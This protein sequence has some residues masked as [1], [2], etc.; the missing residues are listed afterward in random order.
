MRSVPT[1]ELNSW[2]LP[3]IT[4]TLHVRLF[5]TILWR[6][7]SP[8][9]SLLRLDE[10]PN[11]IRAGAH[12]V[13]GLANVMLSASESLGKESDEVRCITCGRRDRSRNRDLCVAFSHVGSSAEAS[14][15]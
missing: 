10:G 4:V 12:H 5:D 6:F 13:H 7:V 15:R 3:S 14:C 11:L 1:C 8:R 2:L 9:S